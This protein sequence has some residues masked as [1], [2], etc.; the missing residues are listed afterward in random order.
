M[1]GNGFLL[2]RPL[3][4]G[5]GA[6]TRRF[7]NLSQVLTDAGLRQTQSGVRIFTFS[8]NPVL[9]GVLLAHVDDLLFAGSGNFTTLLMNALAAFRTGELETLTAKVPII[10]TG[11]LNGKA[12]GRNGI[13][14]RTAQCA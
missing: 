12:L 1:S 13:V 10:F 3:Y 14:I 6:P 7:P 4:G 11:M 9:D 5:R 2:L 8:V